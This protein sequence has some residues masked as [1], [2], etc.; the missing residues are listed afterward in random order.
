MKGRQ[1]RDAFIVEPL[2][3]QMRKS[4]GA[5]RQAASGQFTESDDHLWL[6]DADLCGE[7][8]GVRIEASVDID[9]RAVAFH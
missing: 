2:T 8:A 3:P 1:D 7:N 9:D 4:V 5:T 6:D